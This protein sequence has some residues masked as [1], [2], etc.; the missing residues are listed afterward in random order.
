MMLWEWI[1]SFIQADTFLQTKHNSPC[2]RPSSRY[3]SRYI[4]PKRKGRTSNIATK[5][6]RFRLR[7]YE[8]CATEHQETESDKAQLLHLDSDSFTIGIDNHASR[9]IS[10]NINHFLNP[11]S[12]NARLSRIRGIGNHMLEVK[13]EG[14]VQWPVEDDNGYKHN[15]RIDNVLYVPEAPICLLSPQHWSQQAQDNSPKRHGTW[16]V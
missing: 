5:T 10:N 7:L 13:G 4:L 11:L 16:Y 3:C 14:T 12:T 1:K 9:C 2:K 8:C 15:L 6:G